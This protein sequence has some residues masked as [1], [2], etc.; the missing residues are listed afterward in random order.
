M[1][2]IITTLL[3]LFWF[4]LALRAQTPVS[5][6]KENLYGVQDEV[7]GIILEPL[8]SELKIHSEYGLIAGRQN[9]TWQ[10]YNFS[11]KLLV[12]SNFTRYRIESMHSGYVGAKYIR[13]SGLAEI[14]EK[15]GGPRYILN[16]FAPQVEPTLYPPEVIIK[17]ERSWFHDLTA[18]ETG[19]ATI[20][21]EDQKMNFIDSTGNLIFPV[22]LHRASLVARNYM[23][24]D[25]GVGLMALSTKYFDQR[26]DYLY[27][28]IIGLY[29][30]DYFLAKRK[31]DQ[32]MT[33]HYVLDT[34]GKIIFES[35]HHIEPVDEKYI[36]VNGDKSGLYTYEGLPIAEF[37]NSLLHL[38][39]SEKEK[40]QLVQNGKKGLVNLQGKIILEPVYKEIFTMEG[41]YSIGHRD[42]GSSLLDEN[43]KEIFFLESGEI[44][45]VDLIPGFFRAS[46]RMNGR[47]RQGILDSLGGVVMPFEHQ[48]IFYDKSFDL[49][50]TQTDSMI[51]LYDRKLNPIM[52][53]RVGNYVGNPDFPEFY[54]MSSDSVWVYKRTGEL[55]MRFA[56]G[57]PEITPSNYYEYLPGFFGKYGEIVYDN[58]YRQ[59][60]SNGIEGTSKLV[61][62]GR[63]KNSSDPFNHVFNNDRKWILPDG[64][65]LMEGN[66][67]IRTGTKGMIIVH[68]IQDVLEEKTIPRAGVIDM[69]GQWVLPP[70][71]QHIRYDFDAQVEVLDPVSGQKRIVSLSK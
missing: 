61:I 71:I 24:I 55:F 60:F 33:T 29:N 21:R 52:P 50:L 47:Y 34:L 35:S 25:T 38:M 6:A 68:H 39:G 1:T 67:N 42:G 12:N 49:I 14:R 22:W 9:N 36:I 41:D 69:E 32:G 13:Y 20:T 10:F 64:Y 54:I 62:I 11:G 63:A 8:F 15:T 2:R 18:A 31:S 46:K 30:P 3:F 57:N 19:I 28:E 5:F 53:Y 7:H 56:N 65:A 16:A 66:T 70:A 23:A 40:F 17:F 48:Y 45:F 58:A 51:A 37:E 27:N 59:L 26:S 43:L 4:C 44:A